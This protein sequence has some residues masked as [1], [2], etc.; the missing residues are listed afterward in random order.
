MSKVRRLVL[1]NQMAGPLFRQLAEG[2]A[3]CYVEGAILLTGHPDTLARADQINP[4]LKVIAAPAYNRRSRFHR[5]FSWVCYMRSATRYILFARKGDVVLLVSNPP[6]LGFWVCLLS[7]FRSVPYGVLVYDIYPDVLEQM[8]LIRTGSL[9]SRF[10]RKMNR[11][12]YRRAKTVITI[13]NRMAV[14]LQLQ[15][16]SNETRVAVVPPW[17]DVDVLRPLNRMANPYV[18]RFIGP[19]DIVVLYSGNMGASHDID[20]MLMAARL[21][22]GEKRIRF[23]FI[24]DGEKRGAVEA[25][26]RRYP[27][28]N[29]RYYPFQ[30]EAM[31]PYTLSMADISLVSLDEGMEDLMVPSKVFSYMAAGSAILAIANDYSELADVI[32]GSGCG[33]RVAP[34]KP[35]RIAET[36]RIMIS[37][38]EKLAA[39]KRMSRVLAE[40][41]Y[42]Q[43]AGVRSFSICLEQAGLR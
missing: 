29:V 31:L 25:H 17:A 7:L 1:L 22:C 13:G 43:Q 37:A 40:N 28:S 2:L 39:Y 30:P 3:P 23:L 42:S 6:L 11:Q 9:S 41:R 26:I 20:S 12:V 38:P 36:L 14:R 27:D 35:D 8:G 4:A 10:W 24:G 18:D 5:V 19:S 32:D 16:V 21:L 33:L 15:M 34:R